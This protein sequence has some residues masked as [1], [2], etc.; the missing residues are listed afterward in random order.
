MPEM[1]RLVEKSKIPS[2]QSSRC[3][4][5]ISAYFGRLSGWVTRGAGLKAR[6]W[7]KKKIPPHHF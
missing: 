5:H 3:V 2:A 4:K 1:L 6:D 7:V